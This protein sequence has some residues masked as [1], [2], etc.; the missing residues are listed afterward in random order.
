MNEVR[1]FR[2]IQNAIRVA[3]QV[4][5]KTESPTSC[6][7]VNNYRESEPQ[8]GEANTPQNRRQGGSISPR[9]QCLSSQ[10]SL[11]C[12]TVMI[13]CGAV[14]IT[15]SGDVK[16]MVHAYHFSRMPSL[17][18]AASHHPN[19]GDWSPHITQPLLPITSHHVKSITPL[20]WVFGT[21]SFNQSKAWIQV[22]C[23]N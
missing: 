13:I 17:T 21:I 8:G 6:A 22:F 11:G 3:N 18:S 16:Q 1:S 7:D 4:W 2:S 12:M 23:S 10:K 14:R 5:V 9:R 15:I 20:S 19:P